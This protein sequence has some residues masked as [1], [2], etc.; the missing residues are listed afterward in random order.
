MG[1][2][3]ARRDM[4]VQAVHGPCSPDLVLSSPTPAPEH[5][6]KGLPDPHDTISR[7]SKAALRTGSEGT[8]INEMINQ[9]S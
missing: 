3:G 7:L 2:V 5:L 9:L 8:S 6:I 1:D 4:G